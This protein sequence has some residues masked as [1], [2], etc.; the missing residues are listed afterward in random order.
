ML[1]L[2]FLACYFAQSKAEATEIVTLGDD[3]SGPRSQV[4][5][6]G[7][8]TGRT[9]PP[10]ALRRTFVEVAVGTV[11]VASTQ[12]LERPKVSLAL[13]VQHSE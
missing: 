1:A 9:G 3:R 7:S 4:A 5:R 2:R 6:V 8:G 12:E 11:V 13:S 10:A